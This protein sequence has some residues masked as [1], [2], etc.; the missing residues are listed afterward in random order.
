MLR[1]GV[2]VA[3]LWWSGPL[4]GQPL[5]PAWLATDLNQPITSTTMVWGNLH[6]THLPTQVSLEQ[7]Q[8]GLPCEARFELIIAQFWLCQYQQQWWGFQLA[9]DVLWLTE[10][11]HA[12]QTSTGAKSRLVNQLSAEHAGLAGLVISIHQQSLPAT[13]KF[14]R[15]RHAARLQLVERISSNHVLLWLAQPQQLL[16]LAALDQ[17]TL[18]LA[19][20]HDA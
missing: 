2:V 9:Q 15:F 11:N 5:L 13:E 7:W 10:F 1:R 3:L 19:L 18:M 4:V 16:V 17:Q 20:N 8:Q 14:L 12:L 6:R